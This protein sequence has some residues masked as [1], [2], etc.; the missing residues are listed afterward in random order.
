MTS[1]KQVLFEA[2]GGFADK[3]IK[4]LDKGSTFIVDDRSED[5]LGANQR[6]Y[7]YFCMIFAK[8]TPDDRT[9]AGDIVTVTLNGNVPTS[10]GVQAWVT[11][12]RA[13]YRTAPLSSF[14]TF[15]VGRGEQAKLRS[16]AK[17]IRA[18][19]GSGARYGVKSYKYVCP[20]TA[21]S[22]EKLAGVLETAW[23]QVH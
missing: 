18:I 8:V 9:S 10:A 7:S 16:L 21:A 12:H 11:E 3:R 6:L 2:Y 15:R 13:E 23:Q 17:S 1:L 14:L 22:L 19:T 5:D 20:R 4:R